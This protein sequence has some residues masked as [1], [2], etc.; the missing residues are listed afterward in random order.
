MY[1]RLRGFFQRGMSGS[2]RLSPDAF[3]IEGSGLTKVYR[4]GHRA[5]LYKKRQRGDWKVRRIWYCTLSERDV[6]GNRGAKVKRAAGLGV[7]WSGMGI[8]GPWE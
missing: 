6:D 1:L 3:A 2:K 8:L 7:K 4:K 5:R